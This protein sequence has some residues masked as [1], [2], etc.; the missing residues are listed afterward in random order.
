VC[1]TLPVRLF[2]INFVWGCSYVCLVTFLGW[3]LWFGLKQSASFRLSVRP[4]FVYFQIEVAEWR[5]ASSHSTRFKVKS[6][7]LLKGQGSSSKTI[8][9]WISNLNLSNG[10]CRLH[11]CVRRQTDKCVVIGRIAYADRWFRPA[12][13]SLPLTTNMQLWQPGDRCSLERCS[14]ACHYCIAG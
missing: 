9:H 13:N 5:Y 1:L 6:F 10:L 2:G 3:L 8:C 4:Q 14:R 7:I 12:K 11:G